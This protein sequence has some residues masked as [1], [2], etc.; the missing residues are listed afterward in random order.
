M[1]RLDWVSDLDFCGIESKADQNER[2]DTMR[3]QSIDMSTLLD[4]IKEALPL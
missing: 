2:P 1:P 3:C 4:E